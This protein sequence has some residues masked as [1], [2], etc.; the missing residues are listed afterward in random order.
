MR[1][2]EPLPDASEMC[3]IMRSRGRKHFE[4]YGYYCADPYGSPGYF[5]Y[6]DEQ[7]KRCKEGF[8]VGGSPSLRDG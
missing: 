1:R 6:W 3:L 7:T 2:Q 5:D 8:E 4:K